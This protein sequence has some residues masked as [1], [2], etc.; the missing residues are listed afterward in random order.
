[1]NDKDRLHSNQKP[2]DLLRYLVRTYTNEGDTVLDFTMGSGSTI[3]AALNLNRKA[4]GI[5]MGQCE[6]KNHKYFG[7]DWT[8]VLIDQLGLKEK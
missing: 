7:M 1:M 5:E 8:D 6:K 4:I 2:I 3:K